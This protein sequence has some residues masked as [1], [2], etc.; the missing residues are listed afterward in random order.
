MLGRKTVTEELQVEFMT[1]FSA[2]KQTV[3]PRRK[4]I[5]PQTDFQ[6]TDH[7]GPESFVGH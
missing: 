2:W 4:K 5:V 7:K 3:E 1:A 6:I